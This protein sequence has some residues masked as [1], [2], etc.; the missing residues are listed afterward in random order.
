MEIF[1]QFKILG[2]ETLE[3]IKSKAKISTFFDIFTKKVIPIFV[4]EKKLKKYYEKKMEEVNK[5]FYKL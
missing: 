3:T 1:N 2:K 4:S 5:V